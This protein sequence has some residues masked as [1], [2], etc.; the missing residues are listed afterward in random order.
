MKK[1]PCLDVFFWRFFFTDSTICKSPLNPHLGEYV[2]LVRGILSKSKL[3]WLDEILT[4][5]IRA[6]DYVLQLM[7]NNQQK[8]SKKQIPFIF[9]ENPCAIVIY[10]CNCISIST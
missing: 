5:L 7:M 8:V 2:F 3:I 10:M 9:P 6:D 4:E 1:Y